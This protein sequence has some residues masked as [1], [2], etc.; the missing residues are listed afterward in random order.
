MRTNS[1]TANDSTA[2]SLALSLPPMTP[3]LIVPLDALNHAALPFASVV[4]TPTPPP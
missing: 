1:G 2:E 3:L 4:Q